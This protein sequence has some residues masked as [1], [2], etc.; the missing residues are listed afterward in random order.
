[1]AALD[2]LDHLDLGG[3]GCG[4]HDVELGLLG[5][6]RVGAAAC[7]AATAG[8]RDRDR[9]C[10]SRH[11]ELLLERLHQVGEVEDAHA[12]DLFDP[13]VDGHRRHRDSLY[14]RRGSAA[15]HLG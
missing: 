8:G 13:L 9:S 10:G 15:I 14:E 12:L 3:A 4:Q 11:A 2:D 6:G 1:M 7:A 5:I